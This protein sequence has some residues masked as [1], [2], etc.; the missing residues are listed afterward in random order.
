M[1]F[2]L[3]NLKKLFSVTFSQFFLLFCFIMLQDQENVKKL[4]CFKN[5]CF[6]GSFFGHGG[7]FLMETFLIL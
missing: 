6:W 1:F 7:A 4:K 5:V 3:K 2:C